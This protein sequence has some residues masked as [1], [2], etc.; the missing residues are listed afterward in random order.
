MLICRRKNFPTSILLKNGLSF[1]VARKRLLIND[2]NDDILLLACPDL[3]QDLRDRL[4]VSLKVA[5]P[6]Y[7]KWTD[8]EEEGE[9]LALHFCWWNRYSTSVCLFFFSF[10]IYPSLKL[11]L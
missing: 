5:C 9:F 3:P 6:D 7:M 10:L 4:L 1:I 11:V 8:S 2:I